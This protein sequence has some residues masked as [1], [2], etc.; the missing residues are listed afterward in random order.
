MNQMDIVNLLIPHDRKMP[1]KMEGHG[2]APSN[3][4]LAKYWGK[5]NK[6]LNLPITD[7]LSISLFDKGTSTSI[8]AS[9]YTHDMVILN[10]RE[11]DS[12]TLFAQRISHLLN[13]FRPDPSFYFKITTI[14]NIPSAAGLASSASGFAALILALNDFF[15]WE[16]DDKSL[17]ILARLGSGSASRSLWH[18][19]VE[20]H[21]GV[22]E[23]GMDSYAEKLPYQWPSL[24]LGIL[25]ISNREKN[26]TSREGMNRS[27]Q[28]SPFY[29]A[30]PTQ[31]AQTM[32]KLHTAIKTKD[33]ELL[34][35]AAEQNALAMHATMLTSSPA[36][37][38]WQTETLSQIQKIWQI[39]NEGV[40][41]YFTED[42]GPNLKLLF[43]DEISDIV[44][45]EFRDV[46]IIAP[47]HLS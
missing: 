3:I 1:A 37:C 10:D 6:T 18:G 44:R 36:F 4:A 24:R 22:S 15:Q 20:W 35:S 27:Q 29:S 43:T 47:F 11:I 23:D 2:Y 45:S 13:L 17:S 8:E 33:I 39:R 40:P 46:E 25:I 7:S 32:E 42:A 38:Y 9:P 12:D 5:R 21:A 34:G 31:V 19:F 41:L 30:W 26:I 14:N 16:L 28:T